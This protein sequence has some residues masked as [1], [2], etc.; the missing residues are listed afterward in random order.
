MYGQHK[1]HGVVTVELCVHTTVPKH[2]YSM[3]N[4]FPLWPLDVNGIAYFF[5]NDLKIDQNLHDT[6]NVLGMQIKT[7]LILSINR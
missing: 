6:K 5:Y 3:W 4:F 2:F 7:D 1:T